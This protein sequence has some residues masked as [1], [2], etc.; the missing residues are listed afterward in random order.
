MSCELS[1]A[2]EQLRLDA[3]TYDTNFV[4]GK[5]VAYAHELTVTD[6]PLVDRTASFIFST[7]P[8][9]QKGMLDNHYFKKLEIASLPSF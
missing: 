1:L 4:Q 6:N 8:Q 5:D 2:R 3:R 9:L 7:S